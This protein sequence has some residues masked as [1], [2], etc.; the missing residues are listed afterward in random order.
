MATPTASALP[1]DTYASSS[2]LA[3]GKW[4]KIK[5]NEDGLQFLSNE[6]LKKMGFTDPSKVHVYGYGGTRLPQTLDAS[7]V[8][9]LPLQ[10]CVRTADGIIFFGV[11]TV[12]WKAIGSRISHE[13]NPY[14][15]ASYYFVSDADLREGES[16]DAPELA[17]I[18]GSDDERVS[19]ATQYLLHEVE[20]MSAGH[21]GSDLFGEDFRTTNTRTFTFETPGIIGNE[22]RYNVAF[23]SKAGSGSV[24][25]VSSAGKELGSISFS[26]DSDGDL[27]AR[28]LR[29]EFDSETDSEGKASVTLK[30][31]G[32]GVIYKAMLDFIECSY[33]RELKLTDTP[34]LFHYVVS[35][36]SHKVFTVSGVSDKTMIW[37]VSDPARIKT[38][39]YDLSGGVASFAPEGTGLRRYVVFNPGQYS[40]EPSSAGSVS[41]QD[42]H[43]LETPGMVIITPKEY[44]TQAERIAEMHRTNDDMTVHVLTPE[45]IY[46]EFS[47][48]TPDVTAYRKLLKMWY[49]R[50]WSAT[51]EVGLCL[52][53]ARTTYDQRELTDNLKSAKYPRI[54]TWQST[55]DLTGS[56]ATISETNSYCTDNYI[57]MLDDCTS[58]SMTAAKMRVGVG[59]MPVKSTTE[60]KLMVDKLINFVNNPDYGSWR[61]NVL[62]LA[63]DG[64]YAIHAEQSNKLYDRL[65]QNGGGN[66]LYERMNID[67][68]E[69]G[70]NS[71]KKTYPAAKSRMLNL[72]EE[73]VSLWS[74]IGHA[75]TTSLTGEDMWTYTD[76]TSMTNKH[77]PV[78]Y[79]ASCEFIRFDSD[80][81]SGCE[82]MWLH[83]NSGIISAIAAN[84]KV[85]I[86]NNESFT[87]AFGVAYFQRDG[88]NLPR[89]MGDVYMTTVNNA[90]VSDNRH[91]Y[92]LMGDPAMRVPIPTYNVNVESMADC[93]IES[94]TD[95]ADY[96]VLP[97]LSKA[98]VTGTITNPD[99]SPATDFNGTVVATLHDAEVVVTTK[100]H[101]TDSKGLDGT[102]INY[103]DR[104]NKLFTGYFPV[105]NGQWEAIL[106]LPEEIENATTQARLTLHAYDD[107]VDAAGST[108][109]FFIYG[110][111]DEAEADNID[112]EIVYMYLNNS[113][114]R[115]GTTVGPDPVFKA[116]VRDDSGINISTAGV[117]R[118]LTVVVD[119]NKVYDNLSD[120]FV[121]EQ[122]DPGAGTISYTL[123]GLAEGDHTLE[124]LVWDNAG[125]CSRAGFDFRIAPQSEIPNLNIYTDASPAVSSVTFFIDSPEAVSGL[126]EVF[127]LSGRRVWYNEAPKGD[128]ALSTKW[129]LNDNGGTRVPRGIYLY[130]ATVRNASGKEHRATKKFAVAN[131]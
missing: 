118:L 42:L 108:D 13:Q 52:L 18:Y 104:K 129:N 84:R 26:A 100:G 55:A 44:K 56:S 1:T 6:T 25:S 125:N 112:P 73:G 80:A 24:V 62:L 114:F 5:V 7:F 77:L 123:S 46:N 74:Y 111:A 126:V 127:D 97:G 120:Y 76:L 53:F 17:V 86:S 70:T 3:T 122:T 72:I 16:E 90:G 10:P 30:Y 11:G 99:G 106:L 88:D 102:I 20:Q 79:T 115:S 61:N 22:V 71:Y 68:Y 27:H 36:T 43:A 65:T 91:R 48:G 78:L 113:A 107:K 87:N 51:S 130:R 105:K 103:N 83:A 49:D 63:D 94:I 8:D 95:S 66:L 45:V 92:A 109:K 28:V 59:R 131:P 124:F 96:P 31:A 58:F 67:A 15:S 116:K 50:T 33:T 60:A 117:G 38:V 2:R 12:N 110:W 29:R 75:N 35:K 128:G 39:K 40:L 9:D 69:Y 21:T 121:T 81:V 93:D 37:D 34:L 57:A 32:S 82:S 19:T 14:S 54:L 101:Y 119:N 23:A 47:S 89:R 4:A 85:F 98:K 41:N 64:D